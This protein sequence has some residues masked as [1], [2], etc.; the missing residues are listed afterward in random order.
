MANPGPRN[1][2]VGIDK[3]NNLLEP[4]KGI[5]FDFL[6]D[7]IESL[8][9]AVSKK[10]DDMRAKKG[11]MSIADMFDTQFEMN[12]LTQTSEFCSAVAAA[13]HGAAVSITKNIR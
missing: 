13:M 4:R 11:E 6:V 10:I 7:D 3:K 12:K 5:N 8:T 9:Q 2:W 1:P